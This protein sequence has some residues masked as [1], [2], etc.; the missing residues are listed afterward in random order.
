MF[1]AVQTRLTSGRSLTIGERAWSCPA[2][3]LPAIV[4]I[5]RDRGAGRP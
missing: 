5:E 4:A 1:A 2:G 3:E